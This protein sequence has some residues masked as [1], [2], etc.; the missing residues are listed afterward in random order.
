MEGTY[1]DSVNEAIL[2]QKDFSP[3]KNII[4]IKQRIKV[5]GDNLA[6]LR[7][8]AG[9]S[10]KEVAEIIECAVQTYS[11]YENGRHEPNIE[12]LVRI[13]F[14]YNVT[15]DFIAGKY[16]GIDD[17]LEGMVNNIIENPKFEQ[18]QNKLKSM[19]QDINEL[20]NQINKKEETP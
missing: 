4:S 11:G 10:Q 6:Y 8:K 17:D 16:E 2:A 1:Y 9:L 5:V 3:Y 18:L 7:K 19:E 13:A 15:I 20:K 12:S 14:L